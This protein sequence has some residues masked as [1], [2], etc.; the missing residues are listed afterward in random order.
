[1][2]PQAAFAR[3]DRAYR[4]RLALLHE[5]KA[6]GHVVV[7]TVGPTVPAELIAACGAVALRIAPANGDP[8]AADRYV[9]A[10][11]DRDARLLFA[12]FV[13]GRLDALDLLVIPRS[14]ET[15]HKLYLAL[16]EALRIG[17]KSGGPALWLHDVPHTQRDSSRRYG[18]ARQQELAEQVAA[19]TGRV[20]DAAALRAAVAQGNA[21][22][23]LLQQVQTWRHEGRLD[24]RS[25]HVVLGAPRFMAP[26]DAHET[27][28]AF[29]AAPPPPRPPTPRLFVHG[30]A[31]DHDALHTLVDAAGATVVQDDDEWG[32]RAATPLVDETAADP[33][34]AIFDHHWR[35]VPCLRIHPS[36]PGPPAFI[37]AARAGAVDGVLFHLPRPDDL[38]GWR[39]PDDRAAADAAGLPWLLL[40]DDARDAATQPALRA[41]IAA[42]VA[43]LRRRS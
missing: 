5:A 22:R 39:F 28:A 32:S 24:S 17:L 41:A 35:A 23:A 40:R 6:A 1:V 4:D 43:G 31:L 36:P 7:G 15:W 26:A 11:A 8:A 16:R 21:V 2:T 3:L 38:H 30:V 9:E 19:R 20:A 10:F 25:A 13:A 33:F 27:L 14:S 42:F 29:V 37:A 18:L 12:D 34:A